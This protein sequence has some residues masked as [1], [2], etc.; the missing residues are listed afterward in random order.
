[1][2]AEQGVEPVEAT[3]ALVMVET[4][5]DAW[6][7]AGVGEEPSGAWFDGEISGAEPNAV[8]GDEGG[9]GPVEDPGLVPEASA[10]ATVAEQAVPVVAVS[11]EDKPGMEGARESEPNERRV[12]DPEMLQSLRVELT[13]V[14]EGLLEKLVALEKELKAVKAAVKGGGGSGTGEALKRLVEPLEEGV[15]K[16]VARQEALPALLGPFQSAVETLN[17]SVINV[18][19]QLRHYQEDLNAR[20]PPKSKAGGW[21]L[22]VAVVVVLACLGTY[23]GMS[24]QQQF[25]VLEIP[26]ESGGWREYIWDSYGRAIVECATE[27]RRQGQEIECK[28]AVTAP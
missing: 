14:A 10:E 18:E 9:D 17:A 8:V 22:S 20:R 24:L 23:G 15:G 1:M 19:G 3:E 7:A 21:Q 26:D 5:E 6:A 27:A 16:V 4:D 25:S 28:V 12:I 2:M 11:A 13:Q